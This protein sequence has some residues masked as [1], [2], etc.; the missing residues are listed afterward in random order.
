MPGFGALEGTPEQISAMI[1]RVMGGVRD[2]EKLASE[3][4]EKEEVREKRSRRWV[5]RQL[6]RRRKPPW[7]PRDVGYLAHDDCCSAT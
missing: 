5:F 2:T 7:N 3:L 6:M 1:E 4:S